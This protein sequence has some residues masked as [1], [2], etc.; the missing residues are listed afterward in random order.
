MNACSTMMAA[1]AL[2]LTATASAA[3]PSAG[4]IQVRALEQLQDKAAVAGDMPTLQRIL[5]DDYQLVNPA[6]EIK[7]RQQLLDMLSAATHPYRS[8]V[9]T[10][11]LVRDLGNVIVTVGREDVVPNQSPGAGQV[12]QHRHVTQVWVRRR[13]TWRLSLR[14]ATVVP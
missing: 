11:D 4:E 7:T 8:A 14:H 5:A 12:V 3:T 1:C 2:L 6:G 9:Y 13:G 10:T